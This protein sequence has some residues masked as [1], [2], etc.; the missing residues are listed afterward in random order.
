[1]NLYVLISL[2]IVVVVIIL[3]F[4]GRLIYMRSKRLR[5]KLRMGYVFTNITHELLTPLT[6]LSAS[7]DKMREEVPQLSHDYDLMQI[8]IQR[9]VRM[10]QQILETSKSQAGELKLLCAQGDVMRCP[11]RCDALYP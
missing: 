9:M 7:V 1:M 6:V 5:E 11:G 4:V 3:A 10:L 8:N 2:A